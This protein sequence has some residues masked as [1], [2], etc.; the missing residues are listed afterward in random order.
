MGVMGTTQTIIISGAGDGNYILI[1]E[2]P[3]YILKGV[4][5]TVVMAENDRFDLPFS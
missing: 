4:R 5:Y 1:V 3:V 2:K